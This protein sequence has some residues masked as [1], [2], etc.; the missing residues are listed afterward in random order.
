MLRQVLIQCISMGVLGFL[1]AAVSCPRLLTLA[2]GHGGPQAKR[3]VQRVIVV[4]QHRNV[5]GFVA[6]L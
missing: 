1:A 3:R 2:N 4:V 5:Y 6:M